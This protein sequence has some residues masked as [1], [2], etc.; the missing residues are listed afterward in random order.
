[1][2]RVFDPTQLETFISSSRNLLKSWNLP[3]Q[4]KL[5]T[6]TLQVD[7]QGI[8]P[9]T[10]RDIYL[11][12]EEPIKNQNLKPKPYKWMDRV[13]DPTQLET[14]IS[15]SRNL[16][17]SWNLSVQPK[18]ETQTLQVDGQGIRPYT[19][20]DIYLALEE[21]IKNQN[22]KPK[23]YKWMDRVFDP[24]QLETFIS[25]SR[26]LLKSWNLPVQP[27]LETQTLQVDGQGIRPYTARDIYLVLEEP[28]KELEFACAA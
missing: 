10:A 27:K 24:T 26:N 23:P 17:K 1:M 8:R 11:A 9:Y 18:L 15:S 13:F 19:A 3:V 21:P 6:Q 20:R 28:I 16:L 12:L 25:S 4:P 14:F 22:L 2:D 5:E 7:G